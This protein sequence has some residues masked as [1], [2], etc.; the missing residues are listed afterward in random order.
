MNINQG[1]IWLIDFEPSIGSEIKKLRP[2]IVVNDDRVG[3]FG[4]KIV[5]PI[6][7]WKDFYSNYPWIIRI[8]PNSENGLSKESS[9]ECFQIKSFSVERFEKKI[10]QVDKALLFQI[11]ST[12][13]KTLN[14]VYKLLNS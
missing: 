13:M 7:E 8:N 4:I 3:R 12:I 10:G 11:H 14:P 9:I 5:V 2:A 6:T 1:E